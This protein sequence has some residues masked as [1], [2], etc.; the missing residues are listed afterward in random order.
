M[1]KMGDVSFVQTIYLVYL[2]VEPSLSRVDRSVK[3]VIDHVF[4]DD[5][6]T[7]SVSISDD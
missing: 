5:V 1:T 6:I 2:A 4:P 7:L 3:V